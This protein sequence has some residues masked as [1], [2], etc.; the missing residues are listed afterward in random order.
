MTTIS[1]P[2]KV[3]MLGP[4][5]IISTSNW[6]LE[7]TIL[8]PEW[9]GYGPK[10]TFSDRHAW[11]LQNHRDLELAVEKQPYLVPGDVA[12][13]S[14]WLS[15]IIILGPSKVTTTL[16]W[17]WK[18]SHNWSWV[19]WQWPRIGHQRSPCLV[20][21]KS[22]RPQTDRKEVAMLGHEWRGDDLELALMDRHAWSRK[23][24]RNV[25][26]HDL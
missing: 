5:K 13:T 25:M 6:S 24:P 2:S 10:L 11:P 3:I 17:L 14:S 22:P 15:R 16:S 7:I 21:T 12:M 1:W 23:L 19:T 26:I 20:P 4:R 8:G 9:C 18:G